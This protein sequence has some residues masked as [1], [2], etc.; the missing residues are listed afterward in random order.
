[1]D[2]DDS[3]APGIISQWVTEDTRGKI[4]R[5]A[6]E[7]NAMMVMFLINAIYFNGKWTVE[8]DEVNTQDRPFQLL[9]GSEKQHPMMAQSGE[10]Q[11]LENDGFQAVSLPYGEGQ[12]SM[13]I[14]LP[15]TGDRGGFNPR[16]L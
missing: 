9:N 15:H 7:I 2:F 3:A 4:D 8:F 11:Y 1:M 13:Y 16:A 12:V 10:Y 5:I 14:F 6:E